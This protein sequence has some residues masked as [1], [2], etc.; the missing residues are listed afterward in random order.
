MH[1]TKRTTIICFALLQSL[2]MMG[3]LSDP[4][5]KL[6]I[7]ATVD[8]STNTDYRW[9]TEMSWK[10]GGEAIIFDINHYNGYFFAVCV[11]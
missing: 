10:R 8:G 6:S 7:T 4:R 2:V 5:E 9:K 3:Q 11:R 1:K